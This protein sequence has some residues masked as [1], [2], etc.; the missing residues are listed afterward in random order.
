[1]AFIFG[2]NFN[3]MV[4]KIHGKY[5]EVTCNTTKML[6]CIHVPRELKKMMNHKNG[7]LAKET[8]TIMHIQTSAHN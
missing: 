3:E 4:P 6:Q 8:R 5:T 1:M 7:S 2:L